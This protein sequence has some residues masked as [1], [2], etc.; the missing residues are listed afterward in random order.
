M[1][2]LKSRLISLLRWSEKYTKTDMVYLASGGAWYLAATPLFWLISLGLVLAFANLLPKETYGTYQYVL[3]IADL[4][5]IMVLGGIDVSVGRAAAR[6]QEGSLFEG[7]RAK[8]RWGLLGGL[9][10]ILFGTYYLI[11][12][13]SLL[14]WAFIITGIFI[15][16]WEAPG[17]YLGYLQSK[18]RFDLVNLYSLGSQFFAA[19][20]IVPILFLTDNVLI[21]LTAYLASWGMAR[22]FFFW[23]TL[24]QFPPNTER[25]PQA[26]PYGKHLT[27]M[28]LVNTLASSA[29]GILL[30]HFLGPVAVAVY[31]FATAIPTQAAGVIKIV[32]RVAFPKFASQDYTTLQRTLPRK[33]F[34]LFGLGVLGALVYVVLAPFIFGIFFPQYLSSVP[35]SQVIAVLIALQPFNLFSS[36]FSAQAKQKTLYIYNFVVPGVRLILLFLLIPTFGIWGAVVALV[37]AKALESLLLTVLFY[38]L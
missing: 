7:L 37:T 27:A 20:V 30:F 23:L 6:G 1:T 13:N 5:G 9:G 18:R 26:V 32:N 38:R 36:A 3:L 4:F 2:A 16:F 34:L 19:I 17:L 24:R 14:G 33:V 21:I 8:I 15:P 22:A 11:Q 10:S 35:Y 25:D 31:F 29:G 28:M 12:D